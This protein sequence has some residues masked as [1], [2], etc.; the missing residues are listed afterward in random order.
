[1]CT[2]SNSSESLCKWTCNAHEILVSVFVLFCFVLVV[3]LFVFFSISVCCFSEVWRVLILPIVIVVVLGLFML[4]LENVVQ[5][6]AIIENAYLQYTVM[7]CIRWVQYLLLASGMRYWSSMHAILLF[8]MS[9]GSFR[10]TMV[11]IC[12]VDF[13]CTVFFNKLL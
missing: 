8:Q 2:D 3:C 6:L 10:Q 11:S 12:W 4:F 13:V 1:M 9:S 5:V 7:L